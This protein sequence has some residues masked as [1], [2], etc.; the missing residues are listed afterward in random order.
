MGPLVDSAARAAGTD[1]HRLPFL[2]GVGVDSMPWAARGF[3][4]VS[5]LGEVLGDPARRIHTPRDTLD[6]LTEEGLARAA[7]TARAIAVAAAR[8]IPEPRST[9]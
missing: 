7:R 1:L 4:T 6:L 8:P 3:P 5:L 2:P 9:P